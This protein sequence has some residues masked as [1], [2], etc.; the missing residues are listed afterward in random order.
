MQREKRKEWVRGMATY[1]TAEIRRA[2]GAIRSSRDRLSGT[3]MAG[4][5]RVEAELDGEFYGQAADA[6]EERLQAMD[7]DARRMEGKLDSL[8]NRLMRF[9]QELEELDRQIAAEMQ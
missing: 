8:C 9:A 6:L 1:D 7:A 5:L 3:V 2:A 4:L